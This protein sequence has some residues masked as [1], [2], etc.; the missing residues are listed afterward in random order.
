MFMRTITSWCRSARENCRSS[1]PTAPSDAELKTGAPYASK[2]GVA[3]DVINRNAFQF[4][5]IEIELK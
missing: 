5:F 3:H 1:L 2:A 4:S